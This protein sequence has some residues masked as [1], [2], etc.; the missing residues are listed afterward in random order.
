MQNKPMMHGY[1]KLKLGEFELDSGD[2]SLDL[3]GVTVL[4]GRSGSGKST[5]LRAMSGLDKRTQGILVVNGK[6]WQ[7]G[8]RRMAPQARNIGF[9]FQDAA[10][11][12]HMTVRQNLNYGMKRLPKGV[13]ELSDAEFNEIVSRV[14]IADKLDRAVTY[15]S[16]GERQRVAIA[17]ALL[18]RPDILCMDEPLSALDWRSKSELLALIEDVVAAYKIPLLYITHSP[19]EVERLADRVVFMHDG[20]IETVETLQEALARPDSPLF[21]EEGVVSVLEGLSMPMEAGLHPVVMGE[22]RLWLSDLSEL[23]QKAVRVRVLARDVSIALS[24]PK[25]LSIINH[26]KTTICELIPKGEHR[27]LVRLLM[28][29]GQKLFAEVTNHSAERLHLRV[30]KT[31][32]ALIKSVAVTE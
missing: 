23:T 18:S 4:F 32:F 16:G 13:A 22:D 7:E 30:G 21:A 1:L 31:V 29:D 25:D 9:V 6:I 28:A 19:A 12:P 20:K 17:R 8:S 2:F 24:D 10:L 15:L 11:F 14:G 5:L 26:F 27:T 3:D